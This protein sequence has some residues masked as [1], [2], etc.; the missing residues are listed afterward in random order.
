MGSAS[1][2]IMT[3]PLGILFDVYGSFVSR[4]ICT[5]LMTI[6]L[7]CLMFA[8]EIN[9]LIFPGM[10]LLAAGSFALLV[11]NHPLS[12]LFPK[13]EVIILV[14]GQSVYQDSDRILYFIQ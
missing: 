6:G 14:I 3:F 2:S 4:S 11:T 10:A 13:V 9:Q 5:T 12:Q 8:V 1:L 7:V